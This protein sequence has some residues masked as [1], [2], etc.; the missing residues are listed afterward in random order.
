MLFFGIYNWITWLH[1]LIDGRIN[2]LDLRAFLWMGYEDGKLLD[3]FKLASAALGILK[4][5]S[6]VGVAISVEDFLVL[7]FFREY[8]Y[9][10]F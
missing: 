2:F 9:I 8:L 7:F 6:Y 3:A 4:L 10:N 5:T 1:F